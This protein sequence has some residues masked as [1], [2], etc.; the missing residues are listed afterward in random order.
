[1]WRQE[2]ILPAATIPPL[3]M[4]GVGGIGSFTVMALAKMGA[5]DITVYDPD[6]VEE[7]NIPN[8]LYMKAHTGSLKVDALR[9]MV[10]DFSGMLIETKPM[11]FGAQV[12]GVVLSG[13][14]SMKDRKE[15]WGAVKMK[16]AV[17]LYIEARMGA[18][19]ARIHSVNPCDPSECE[20]YEGTLYDDEEALEAPC[21]ARAIAYTGFMIAALIANQVKKHAMRQ[22]LAKEV[23]MDMVT[24]SM[25]T[26]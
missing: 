24:L 5:Q 18:E 1:M 3:T 9:E 7:H 23:I 16:A 4:I 21:T 19:V 10:D 17:P 14:D 22:V 13:V 12:R 20:W 26:Q 15:I 8:Q 6:T 2:D 25:M 11:R